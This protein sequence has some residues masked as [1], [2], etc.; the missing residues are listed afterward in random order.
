MTEGGFEVFEVGD[1]FV[2]LGLHGFD[3]GDGFVG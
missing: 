2:D 3:I 1:E